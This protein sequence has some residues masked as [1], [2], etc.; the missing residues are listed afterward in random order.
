MKSRY[1]L[2]AEFQAGQ[3][4]WPWLALAVVLFAVMTCLSLAWAGAQRLD[5]FHAAFFNSCAFR[6]YAVHWQDTRHYPQTFRYDFTTS[7]VSLVVL[8]IW[9][10]DGPAI[11]ISKDISLTCPARSRF[12]FPTS[13]TQPVE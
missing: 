5:L 9:I 4:G 6:S 13:R 10:E 12:R 8:V 1:G 3:R 11:T 7:P 2:V